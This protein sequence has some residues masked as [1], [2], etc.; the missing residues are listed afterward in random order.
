MLA[1]TGGTI[2]RIGYIVLFREGRLYPPK[3]S[4]LPLRE[5]IKERG[6]IK[7][8]EK[9]GI[10]EKRQVRGEISRSFSLSQKGPAPIYRGE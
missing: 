10:R 7:R 3:F 5:R 8:N 6:S 1:K 4:P 9:K 2:T